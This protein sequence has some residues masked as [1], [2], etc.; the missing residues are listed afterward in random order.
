VVDIKTKRGGAF[1]YLNE[2]KPG[3]ILQVQAYMKGENADFGSVLYVDREGQNFMREFDVPRA[4]NRPEEAVRRLVSIRDNPIP[5]AP[6]G[7]RIVRNTNKGPDSFRVELP[8]QIGW[9]DLVTCACKKAL[10]CKSIPKG[11]V[12]KLHPATA[13][14][15]E[16]EVPRFE[17]HLT[18]EG[19]AVRSIVLD[20]LEK[21][22]PD[23]RFELM[24]KLVT[25]PKKKTKKGG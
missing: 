6:V 12:G 14:L 2:A 16:P 3:N 15:R 23:E 25:T 10:P 1:S 24:D 19:E 8:W 22:Y 5:P 18:E 17:V 20:L 11:I 13:D 21:A 7:L 4:D 9:C